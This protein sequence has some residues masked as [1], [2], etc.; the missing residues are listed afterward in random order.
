MNAPLL[1]L[2]KYFRSYPEWR[3][4]PPRVQVGRELRKIGSDYGGYYLD[5][6]ILERDA[7]IYSL[8]VGEDISF[9]L[10]LIKHYGVSIHAFDPTPKV[11]TWLSSQT[12]P[13]QFHFY[14][15]GIAHFDGEAVFYLPTQQRFVSH[16]TVRARQFS[17]DSIRVPMMRLS[18]AMQRL[19]HNRIDVLKMDIEG[20]EYSV[21]EDLVRERISVRQLL[22]EFHHRFSNVGTG[23]TREA[24]ARLEGYGFKV[25]HVCP[26]IQVLTMMRTA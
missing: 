23:R 9:D 11:K 8:G 7:I 4:A 3:F 13:A 18:T 5:C 20:E 19:G 26:R 12:L 24:L 14:D 25:C 17:K 22:I 21:L 6:S 15:V 16:S 1:Q 2:R 10:G